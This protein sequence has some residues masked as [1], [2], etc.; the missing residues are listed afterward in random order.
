MDLYEDEYGHIREVQKFTDNEMNKIKRT[1]FSDELHRL[2]N[3]EDTFD[4]PVYWKYFKEGFELGKRKAEL[5]AE[6]DFQLLNE[7]DDFKLEKLRK[8]RNEITAIKVCDS[9]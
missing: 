4:D 5:E 1:Y 6:V 8:L 7:K 2:K 3:Q 9:T